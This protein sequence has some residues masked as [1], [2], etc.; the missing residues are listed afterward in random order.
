MTQLQRIEFAAAAMVCKRLGLMSHT[1]TGSGT[2]RPRKT[3]CVEGRTNHNYKGSLICIHCGH[4][5]P[6]PK[7]QSEISNFK[8]QI[9]PDL[10]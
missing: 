5:K 3:P 6:S 8:S 1:T 10:S 4:V 7:P 2:A 9:T